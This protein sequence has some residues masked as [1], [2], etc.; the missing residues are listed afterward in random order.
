MRLAH[1]LHEPQH[2]VRALQAIAP[3]FTTPETSQWSLGIQREIVKN[4][5]IDLSYVGTKATT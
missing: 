2:P 1:G 3:D 5:V 4:G